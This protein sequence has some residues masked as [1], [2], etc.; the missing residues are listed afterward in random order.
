MYVT[1]LQS[2][3]VGSD[4]RDEAISAGNTETQVHVQDIAGPEI[5]GIL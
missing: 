4:Q 1:I 2:Y 3:I 5:Q